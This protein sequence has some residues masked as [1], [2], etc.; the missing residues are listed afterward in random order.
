MGANNTGKNTQQG[1]AA[2]SC[3]NCLKCV[4]F[5]TTWDANFPNS[6]RVFNIKSRYKPSFEVFQSTGN[7][8]PSFKLKEGLK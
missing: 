7:H 6:C 3:P 5:K 8:C 1:T 2:N 4:Y